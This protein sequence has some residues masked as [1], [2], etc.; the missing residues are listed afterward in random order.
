MM[1]RSRSGSFFNASFKSSFS[2]FASTPPYTASL[3][4]PRISE[5]SSSFPSKSVLSGSSKE[6]S[7]FS[8]TVRRRYIKISFSMQRE[9]YVAS[10][11]FLSVRK[12]LMA[13]MSPMVPMEM[14]SSAST[15]VFSNLRERYTTRRRL[16]SMSFALTS[17]ASLFSSSFFS[18]SASSSGESGSGSASLP[19]R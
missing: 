12:E 5:R 14:R 7:L 17:S 16:C 4:V 19:H 11:I 18:S 10:L 1:R 9:A 6:T 8:F 13:L 15:P 3:S 2:T